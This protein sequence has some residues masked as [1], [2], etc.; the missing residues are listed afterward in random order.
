MAACPVPARP[1]SWRRAL[2]H[3]RE[4]GGP[5]PP[6]LAGT[7][8]GAAPPGERRQQAGP[9]RGLPGLRGGD[10]R[11]RRQSQGPGPQAAPSGPRT[12]EG[13]DGPVAG[14]GGLGLDCSVPR[15]PCRGCEDEVWGGGNR[16]TVARALRE[17]YGSGWGQ[18]THL[19]PG[20]GLRPDRPR[21]PRPHAQVSHHRVRAQGPC[22]CGLMADGPQA[23]TG[24]ALSPW[25]PPST[26][27]PAGW[28]SRSWGHIP[29][30]GTW[31]GTDPG[32]DTAIA[33]REDRAAGPPGARS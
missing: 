11:P 31:P 17:P 18:V 28:P 21:C 1:G 5:Q 8:Q 10:Q 12:S 30:G 3:E 25:R 14:G 9:S 22:P 24:Q 13:T 4:P 15:F 20:P 16:G 29:P 26:S 19:D 7:G 6:E 2:P 23:H 33:G 32:P 27:P